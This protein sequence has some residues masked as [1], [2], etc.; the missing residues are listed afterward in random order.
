MSE[1]WFI[2]AV[3]KRKTLEAVLQNM[4]HDAVVYATIGHIARHDDKSLGISLDLHE[5][6]R[7]ILD[8]KVVDRIIELVQTA[9]SVIV[10]S[11][12]DEAGDVIA[13]DIADV[14]NQ[15]F[16]GPVTRVRL[17]GIDKL[18]VE[19]AIERAGPIDYRAAA[20]GRA[21]T[22][23]DRLIGTTY[24][25]PGAVVGRRQTALLAAVDREKD[26]D[27][28]ARYVIV[29][30]AKDHGDYFS[31]E[32]GPDPIVTKADLDLLLKKGI[33]PV[34]PGDLAHIGFSA[35]HFGDVLVG[36]SDVAQKNENPA[37]IADLA[38]SCQELYMTGRMSYPRT[39]ARGYKPQTINR[40]SKKLPDF[41]PEVVPNPNAVMAGPGDGPH[42]AIYPIGKVSGSVHEGLATPEGILSEVGN[43]AIRSTHLWPGQIPDKDDLR[44]ALIE[45]GLSSKTARELASRRWVRW[46]GA[47]P[48]GMTKPTKSSFFNRSPDAVLLDLAIRN[49]IGTPSSWP[50]LISKSMEKLVE[51]NGTKLQLTKAGQTSLDAAP[52]F[53]KD[54]EFSN[55]LNEWLAK[56]PART[57]NEPW[58]TMAI[59]VMRNL[60]ED[61]RNKIKQSLIANQ[62]KEGLTPAQMGVDIKERAFERSPTM[63]PR[64]N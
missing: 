56:T 49:G 13:C 52:A 39:S 16:N 53:L 9:D 14:V 26:V 38:Q 50:E 30:P 6:G 21:K 4:G 27:L 31:I 41:G 12:A 59:E 1:V 8:Q 29:A 22:I 35:R 47:P 18:S 60:P 62:P 46:D 17:G 5:P 11:D 33:R 20:P 24:S 15:H 54:P 32:I 55:K 7:K 28:A 10:A 44:H 23:I 64:P 61:A 3:G 42:D 25:R 63:A 37:K 58:R 43:A 19:V 2:E 51:A 34:Q 48:P 57:D 45:A 36:L 40:I